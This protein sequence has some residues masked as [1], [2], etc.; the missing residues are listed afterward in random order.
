M[1]N[2]RVL[3]G[4]AI[5][6][7]AA[8]A[9]VVPATY[10]GKPKLATYRV[11]LTDLT[12]GQP[13]S[14]PVAATHRASLH[15]F[16]VGRLATDELAAIAQ[17]GNE[18]P[19]FNLFDGSDQV[20]QAVD[21]GHPLTASG[22]VVGSFTDTATF[23]IDGAPGD[24]F[25]L[26]TMLICTNDGFLGLDAVKLPRHGSEAFS[27]NGYDAGREQNTEASSD[28]VD[29]CSALNPSHPLAGDPNGNN[30]ASVATTPPEPIHHHPG[31]QGGADLSPSFHGWTDPVATVT[32]TRID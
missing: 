16:R 6:A 7:A 24:R 1:P 23:E 12:Q 15:M 5:V 20:T 14:P 22:T 18:A 27:L 9:A 21:V 3:A 4:V 30:D 13:F 17:D 19:M 32:I 26:A 28:I 10:A 11:T 2:K 25:S 31:I 29:P 8:L